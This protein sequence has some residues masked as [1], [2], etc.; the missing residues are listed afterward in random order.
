MY[1]WLH[2]H[3]LQPDTVGDAFLIQITSARGVVS[4]LSASCPE[5]LRE[6]LQSLLA[7]V[8]IL[9]HFTPQN[10]E[11]QVAVSIKAVLPQPVHQIVASLQHMHLLSAS[12]WPWLSSSCDLTANAA[13]SMLM[14]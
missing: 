6:H 4:K 11:E 3:T 10:L 1:D 13:R 5:G 9:A 2:D 12:S 8:D 14:L 7:N